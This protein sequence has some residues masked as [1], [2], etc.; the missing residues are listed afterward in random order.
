VKADANRYSPEKSLSKVC[1]IF[2]PLVEH[3]SLPRRAWLCHFL[4]KP[5]RR[6]ERFSHLLHHRCMLEGSARHHHSVVRTRSHRDLRGMLSFVVR[7]QGRAENALFTPKAS[8]SDFRYREGRA[9]SCACCAMW[10]RSIAPSRTTL[11]R[12]SSPSISST[13]STDMR[14]KV[15]AS[16]EK[17]QRMESIP[18]VDR[19]IESCLAIYLIY[20]DTVLS[21]VAKTPRELSPA[22]MASSLRTAFIMKPAILQTKMV[23][24][25]SLDRETGR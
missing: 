12:T 10:S 17:Y 9:D 15:N 11:D 23:T 24:S 2:S 3:S 13:S 1:L 4:D 21:S 20:R 7:I 22:S 18:T 6:R 16:R 5:R 8:K 19:F 25:L 14:R